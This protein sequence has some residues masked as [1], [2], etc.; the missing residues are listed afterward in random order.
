MGRYVN[1]YAAFGW[2]V[3]AEECA[4]APGHEACTWDEECECWECALEDDDEYYL[5]E[6]SKLLNWSYAGHSEYASENPNIIYLSSSEIEADMGC[7][8]ALELADLADAEEAMRA[9]AER[10]GVRLPQDSP[11]WVT[12]ATYG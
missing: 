4:W 9:E 6:H 10:L 5:P 7:P 11:R 12:W 3:P 8:A 1:G 2:I